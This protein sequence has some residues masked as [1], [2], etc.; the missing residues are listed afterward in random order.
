[1]KQS[2]LIKKWLY[3]FCLWATTRANIYINNETYPSL[4]AL[5]GRFM[6]DGKT[7]QARLQYFHG[8]PYLCELDD[9]VRSRF[10]APWGPQVPSHDGNNITL[11]EPVVILASR[12]NCPFVT[13]AA[14]AESLHESVKF[15]IVYNYN[16]EK[17][18][19]SDGDDV[20]V[21]M[22]AQYGNSKL[23]LLSVTHSTGQA[24]KKFLS[25]QPENIIAMG[26]PFIGFDSQTP[27]GT[28]TDQDFQSI[29]LSALGL[30]FML[31][32]FSGCLVILATSY[33]A[34]ALQGSSG[35]VL[36]RRLLTV[37]EVHSF[38][39]SSISSSAA[40]NLPSDVETSSDTIPLEH[41]P[42]N[43]DDQEHKCAICLDDIVDG[44][45]AIL[46]CGHKYHLDC[47]LPWLTERQ[48]KC[49]L[50]K[51]DV[52]AHIRE[53]EA[54]E[55]RSGGG[56]ITTNIH[57]H[58]SIWD[59]MVSQHRWNNILLID[60]DSDSD[61]DVDHLRLDSEEVELTERR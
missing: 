43:N 12:G 46:P 4:P 3:F 11:F 48:S 13:K 58:F 26:G 29:L 57:H 31:I 7:Y 15:L 6:L 61:D 27:S 30:F 19:G 20:L 36:Q 49:P 1:M 28:F 5:F 25:E 55:I 56:D 39:S 14:V 24:I 53:Q 10:V 33:H 52:L 32:S 9:Y 44:T 42:E 35:G 2:L 45:P 21:P 23:V 16:T 51:F 54:G 34:V 22:Y 38:V 37:E 17:F 18:D 47:I 60:D 59:R 41:A 40:T 8:N 50:C